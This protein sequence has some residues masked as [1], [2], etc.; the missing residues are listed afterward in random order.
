MTAFDVVS[1]INAR[2][3]E[4]NMSKK[5]LAS[6]IE[7]SRNTL[8]SWLSYKTQIPL[9][10]TLIIMHILGLDMEVVLYEED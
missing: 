1:A 2:M 9:D 5:Q 3:N 8:L 6:I 4:M 7:V 10:Y